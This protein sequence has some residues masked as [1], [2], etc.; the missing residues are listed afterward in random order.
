MFAVLQAGGTNKSKR[1][2]VEINI[3]SIMF[4]SRE[5]NTQIQKHCP[6]FT[7][8]QFATYFRND[9]FRI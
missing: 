5:V 4:K 7:P 3:S 6:D 8:R 9:I 1:S 2:N